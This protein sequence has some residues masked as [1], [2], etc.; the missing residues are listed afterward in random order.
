MKNIPYL[1]FLILAVACQSKKDNVESLDEFHFASRKKINPDY[2]YLEAFIKSDSVKAG[3]TY[4]AKVFLANRHFVYD[5]DSIEPIIRYQ[6]KDTITWGSLYN[7]GKLAKVINDTAYIQFPVSDGG[8]KK[9]STDRQ[10]WRATI[11]VP[12]PNGDTTFY[13]VHELIIKK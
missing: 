4:T 3:E 5:G 2:A 11:Q 8:F 1:F 12:R 6:Y 9:E 10:D 7:H 13:L